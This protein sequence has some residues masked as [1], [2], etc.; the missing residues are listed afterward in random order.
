M[1]SEQY[2]TP[3]PTSSSASGHSTSQSRAT[4]A[5]ERAKV[6]F[7][8]YRRGDAND[9]DGYVA[10][11][12]AVLSMFEPELIRRVTDPRTG[13]STTE[14]FCSFMPNS[15][16]LKVYCDQQA[17]RDARLQRYRQLPSRPMLQIEPP[18]PGPGHRANVLVRASVPQ[19]PAMVARAENGADPLD[20]EYV[21]EGIRVPITW[22]IDRPMTDPSSNAMVARMAAE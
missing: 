18:P 16:E 11:I 13:I 3:R 14:K 20:F 8:G 2:R 7:A 21:S 19:Y 4:Y 6:L 22:L 12:A 10:S 15:G 9:P 5:T 17:E 1:E